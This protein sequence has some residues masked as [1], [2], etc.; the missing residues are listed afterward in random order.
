MSYLKLAF[1][2]DSTE[3]LKRALSNPSK[4]F[5]KVAMTKIL[6][7]KISELNNIQQDKLEKFWHLIDDIAHMSM[8]KYPS[9]IILKIV[10]DS[11]IEKAYREEETEE[12]AERLGNIYELL[13]LS[14][15]YDKYEVGEAMDKFLEESSLIS[16]Q[17]T[18][19]GEKDKVRL[20]TI[21]ASKG[22]EFKYVFIVGLEDTLFPSDKKAF[23]NVSKE[24]AEEERR[25]FYVAITRAREK[26]YLT[27]AKE[28]MLWGK[29]QWNSRSEFIDDIP[30]ELY[31]EVKHRPAKNN[32]GDSEDQSDDNDFEKIV[33]YL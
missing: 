32:W 24:E 31:I 13:A 33:V 4:G 15:E 10:K 17:D 1:N 16:D 23:Q 20:M 29:R 11:G 8:E 21:H 9:E 26:L 22:L 2:K 14:S 12:A 25:L 7:G 18:D 3:D 6:S 30:A 27:H 5:G 19:T 28:R